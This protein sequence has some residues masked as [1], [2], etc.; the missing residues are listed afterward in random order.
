MICTESTIG[1]PNSFDTG[2]A[3]SLT[4]VARL[5]NITTTEERSLIAWLVH[6]IYFTTFT[7]LGWRP[8][9]HASYLQ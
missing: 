4:R 8:G 6:N 3:V 2:T 7:D 9:A 1:N 5:G